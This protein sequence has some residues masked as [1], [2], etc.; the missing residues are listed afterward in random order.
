[1][2]AE[3]ALPVLLELSVLLVSVAPFAIEAPVRGE[4][5]FEPAADLVPE[6]FL[7]GRIPEIH[8]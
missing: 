8:G 3:P 5:G 1:V 6:G 4:V 2:V 7:L